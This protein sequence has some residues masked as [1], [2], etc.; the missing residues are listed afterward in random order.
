MTDTDVTTSDTPP[1][2]VPDGR[3]LS[4][5][6]YGFS[7]YETWSRG[8]YGLDQRPVRNKATGKLMAVSEDTSGLRDGERGYL[9][10]KL[11]NDET[12]ARQ[13]TLKVHRLI[14]FVNTGPMPEGMQTRHLDGDPWNNRWEPG[15]EAETKAAGGN[16]LPGTG[17]QQHIDQ[18]TAGTYSPPPKTFPC[19]NHGACG[20]MTAA[21][22][23]R[24]Q[25]C[26]E[27]AGERAGALLKEG[28]PLR[29]VAR[30]LHYQNDVHVH[31]LARQ[32][33][34]Y[35]GS[36]EQARTQQQPLLRRMLGRFRRPGGK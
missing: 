26:R 24:C 25:P 29:A 16:L 12:P 22:D 19:I 6:G 23:C 10:V 2:C 7:K 31:A 9:K 21:P 34:G 3:W 14:L 11:Y 27:Q 8:G 18:K 5:A 32:Y 4:L 33:G 1:G 28:V 13:K 15:D 30:R 36:L 20:G 17:P 35:R